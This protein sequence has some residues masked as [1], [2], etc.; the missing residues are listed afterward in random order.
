MG[1][2]RFNLQARNRAQRHS[3]RHASCSAQ[4]TTGSWPHLALQVPAKPQGP[5]PELPAVR[6]DIQGQQKWHKHMC[7]PHSEAQKQRETQREWGEGDR[8]R[9]HVLHG[10][11]AP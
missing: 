9:E 10:A 6:M 1:D 5:F 3:C 8:E 7:V 2:L 4:G 11:E